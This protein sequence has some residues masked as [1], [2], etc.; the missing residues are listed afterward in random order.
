MVCDLGERGGLAPVAR[1]IKGKIH[2][3]AKYP[4]DHLPVAGL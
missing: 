1:L 4:F 3:T 2:T